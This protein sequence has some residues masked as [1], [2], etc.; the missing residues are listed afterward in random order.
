MRK[1]NKKINFV[2]VTVIAMSVLALISAPAQK[3][4]GNFTFELYDSEVLVVDQYYDYGTLHVTSSA[5][6]VAGGNLDALDALDSSTADVSDGYVNV[7]NAWDS[8]NVYFSGGY[9][10]NLGAYDSSRVRFSGGSIDILEAFGSSSMVISGGSVL[11]FLNAYG[12]SYTLFDG[13]NFAAGDGLTIDSNRRVWGTGILTG[14][15]L[16]DTSWSV[17]IGINDGTI[18]IVPAP[19]ALYLAGLGIT[20]LAGLRRKHLL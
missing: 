12:D 18:Q 8:S 20:V 17:N 16:D 11:T 7:L 5:F 9:A 13:K 2:S 1:M 14:Q 10:N 4:L 6:I 3:C 19:A 15:W